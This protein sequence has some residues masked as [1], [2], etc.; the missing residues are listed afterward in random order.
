[1][2]LTI[3]VLVV[4]GGG[5]AL[6]SR[7]RASSSVNRSPRR[8]P[9]A[10]ALPRGFWPHQLTRRFGRPSKRDP[11]EAIVFALSVAAASIAEVGGNLASPSCWRPC[12]CSTSLGS[13]APWARA[14]AAR[15]RRPPGPGHEPV[16]DH[17]LPIRMGQG[18][19]G[20]RAA[21][22]EAGFGVDDALLWAIGAFFLSFVPYVGLIL[23]LI[24][25][26]SSLRGDRSRRRHRDRARRGEP[27][28]GRRERART[29][30]E[31]QGPPRD[32]V[33]GV[34]DVLFK[35]LADRPVGALLA[36]PL[37]VLI[38]LVLGS[39]DRTSGWPDP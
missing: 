33:V 3:V 31:Q 4:I 20:R 5:L 35:V 37:T 32:D 34:H 26:R 39:N 36:M 22:R 12:C 24:R 14:S 30:H 18:N 1:M 25:R 11:T 15:T 6:L 28:R 13:R 21:G 29:V 16:R 17:L 23:A 38:V 8:R 27:Q 7:T 9:A 2:V 10:G 19:H